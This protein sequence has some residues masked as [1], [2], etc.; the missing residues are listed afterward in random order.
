MP[1]R[2]PLIALS[3]QRYNVPEVARLSARTEV[4]L[5]MPTRG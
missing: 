5:A 4:L 3:A 1:L 2:W